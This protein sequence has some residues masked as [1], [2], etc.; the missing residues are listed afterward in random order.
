MSELR[1]KPQATAWS[2]RWWLTILTAC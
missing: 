1:I 2:F